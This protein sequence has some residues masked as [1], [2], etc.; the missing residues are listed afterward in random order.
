[1]STDFVPNGSRPA[2]VFPAVPR[3]IY[4]TKRKNLSHEGRIGRIETVETLN[5]F[6]DFSHAF[7]AHRPRLDPALAGFLH[8]HGFLPDKGALYGLA[9][10]APQDPEAELEDLSETDT[11][12]PEPEP[13]DPWLSDFQAAILPLA[14]GRYAPALSNRL[15]FW[16]LYT[17]TLPLVPLLGSV[18]QGHLIRRD[19]RAQGT[20]LA[21]PMFTSHKDAPEWE[22]T[23]Q[24]GGGDR[25]L[26]DL[27][28]QGAV[29]QVTRM[30]VIYDPKTRNPV[31]VSAVLLE[32]AL[33]TLDRSG[34]TLTSRR[35]DVETGVAGPAMQFTRGL[36]VAPEMT[37]P[38]TVLLS[39]WW[40]MV[41]NVTAGLVRL[42]VGVVVQI[43]L[44]R[45]AEE[46][47]TVIIDATDRIDAAGHQIHGPV[48]GG[49]V[50]VRFI[51]EFGV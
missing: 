41:R 39:N 18:E 24:G 14:N 36:P 50:A 38:D 29:S 20:I 30:L 44:L 2:G 1:M 26:L 9:P 45:T 33:D 25:I 7:N 32:G 48:M 11:T 17:N 3:V 47:D 35:I 49:E 21:R 16:R 28:P 22:P 42:P 19:R 4:K 43:D 40:L 27:P 23:P 46:T 34:T 31:I 51:K 15:F 10:P 37:D 8:N 5:L 6:R 12:P 13:L